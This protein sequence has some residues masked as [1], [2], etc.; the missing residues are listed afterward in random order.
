MRWIIA[1]CGSLRAISAVI[2]SKPGDYFKGKLYI[3]VLTTLG[4]KC[5]GEMVNGRGIDRNSLVLLITVG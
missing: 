3:Q 1:L 5:L 4:V 2:R